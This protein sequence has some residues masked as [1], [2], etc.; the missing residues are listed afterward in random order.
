MLALVFSY[1]CDVVGCKTVNG[2]LV[3]DDPP[4]QQIV[5]FLTIQQYTAI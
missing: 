5:L 4:H 3:I 1:A 2:R